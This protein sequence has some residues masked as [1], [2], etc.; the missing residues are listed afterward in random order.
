MSARKPS[1]RGAFLFARGVASRSNNPDVRNLAAAYLHLRE[2]AESVERIQKRLRLL[3]IK[4]NTL[5]AD[6]DGE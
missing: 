5:I 4:V 1:H 3:L 6:L 2:R